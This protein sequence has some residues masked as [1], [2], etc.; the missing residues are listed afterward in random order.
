MDSH[1]QCDGLGLGRRFDYESVIALGIFR[2]LHYV[3]IC[4]MAWW[5]EILHPTRKPVTRMPSNVFD[6]R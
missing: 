6:L 4:G 3:A 2:P 5:L 1:G